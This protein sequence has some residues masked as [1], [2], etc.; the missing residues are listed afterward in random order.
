MSGA[1]FV[2]GAPS[3]PPSKVTEPIITASSGTV[4]AI[5]LSDGQAGEEA[6]QPD[7]AVARLERA[8]AARTG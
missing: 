2:Q 6:A 1:M 3:E 7:L 5:G 4:P 8:T